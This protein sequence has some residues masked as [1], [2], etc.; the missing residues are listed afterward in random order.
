[1]QGI[2]LQAPKLVLVAVAACLLAAACSTGGG[3]TSQFTG[4]VVFLRNSGQLEWPLYVKGK[5]HRIERRFARGLAVIIADQAKGQLVILNPELRQYTSLKIQGLSSAS[6]DP[7]LFA[8]QRSGAE[9]SKSGEQ[10]VDGYAC[11]KYVLRFK[12]GA[13]FLSYDVSEKLQFPLRIRLLLHQPG[14]HLSWS[15]LDVTGIKVHPVADSLFQVPKGYTYSKD[16][17]S[18]L[19]V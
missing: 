9:V 4:T 1:M 16:L 18:E 19:G 17:L 14:I 7:L 8:G 13:D 11:D 12:S 10:K 15:G 5:E 3:T 6:L 2:R